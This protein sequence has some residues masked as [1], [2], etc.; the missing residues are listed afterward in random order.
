VP[1]ASIK[2]DEGPNAVR[3]SFAAGVELELAVQDVNRDRTV[4]L[5]LADDAAWPEPHERQP[6]RPLFHERSRD[7]RVARGQLAAYELHFLAEI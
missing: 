4:R 3:S 1:H 6:Q 5:V 2:R 7:S